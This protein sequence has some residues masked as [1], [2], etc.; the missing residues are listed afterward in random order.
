[1]TFSA[2]GDQFH[3]SKVK[4]VFSN[5]HSPTDIAH[6]GRMKGRPYGSGYASFE[7]PDTESDGI[8][9]LHRLVVPILDDMKKAGADDFSI[10][11]TY[12]ADSGAIGFSKNEIQM[13]C[14]MD[15]DLPIDVWI[16]DN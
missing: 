3:P 5:S 14:E 2:S 15:C 7:V 10:F 16:E 6:N 8:S 13:I 1:M 12:T 11:I 4:C 9:Y